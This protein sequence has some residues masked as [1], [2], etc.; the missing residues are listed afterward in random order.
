MLRKM[1]MDEKN[2]KASLEALKHMRGVLRG[3]R[4]KPPNAPKV[5]SPEVESAMADDPQSAAAQ[6]GP[7]TKLPKKKEHIE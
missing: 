1:N 5:P 3:R 2:K 7:D 4:V 6:M